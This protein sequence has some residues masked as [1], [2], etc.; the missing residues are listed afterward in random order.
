MWLGVAVQFDW[1]IYV[2]VLADL[3]VICRGRGTVRVQSLVFRW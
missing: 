2:Q 3:S 1:Q